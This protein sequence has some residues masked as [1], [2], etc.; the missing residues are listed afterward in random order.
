M[1]VAAGALATPAPEAA[2]QQALSDVRVVV[3]DARQQRDSIRITL[4]LGITA[5]AMPRRSSIYLFPALRSGMNESALPPVVLN[6]R[7][8]GKV[9]AREE[10]LSKNNEAKYA[11]Y[12]VKNRNMFMHKI[13]YTACV[14]AES[15]MKD[16][17]VAMVREIRDCRGS[18]HRVSVEVV[19]DGIR[20]IEKPVRGFRYT[21]PLK[22]ITPPREEMKKREESGSAQIVYRAGRAVI[23]P[24]LGDN[25]GELGRI[26]RTIDDIGR[27]RGAKITSV[28]ISS[29]ASPEGSWQSNL[30]LSERRA[31]SL[32]SWVGQNFG[33]AGAGLTA[34]G[35]GEDWDGLAVLIEKDAVIR[36]AEKEDILR[37]I[38]GTGVFDGRENA[39]M[40]YKGGHLYRYMLDSLFPL[41]RRSSYRIEFTVPE[42]SMETI[43][44]T[45]KTNPAMLSLH[46]LYL[47]A[48]L[49]E[50]ESP[51]FR[52]I[53]RKAAL[54]YPG[55][56]INRISMAVLD[57]MD[58][59]IPAAR[60]LL[61]GLENDPDAW[62]PLSVVNAREGNLDEAEL[63]AKK[64]LAAGNPEAALHL[65]LLDDYRS[66]EEKFREEESEWERYGIN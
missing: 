1:I 29:Y 16:A 38:H 28:E 22:L 66:K 14:P 56:K 59:N 32:V 54:I 27:I 51:E 24:S 3:R 6:G 53:I 17:N 31:A 64:S 45:Y 35:Y 65:E 46:E 13:P 18:F 58:N 62:L 61:G 19:A 25:T 5:A 47:L 30:S 36:P 42:Y 10:R 8:Q 15:W 12:T 41:L 43:K 26:R 33:I 2:A 4:D 44:E 63:Y 20:F 40:R 50:P 21:P 11:S 49:Y 23:E 52:D 60:Q 37:I 9:A 7:T 48:N 55:E 34:K 57:I 39:L